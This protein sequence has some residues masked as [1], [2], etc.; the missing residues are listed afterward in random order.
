MKL[1]KLLGTLAALLALSASAST[2]TV[3]LTVTVTPTTVTVAVG[4]STTTIAVP[5]VVVTPPPVTTSTPTSVVYQNGVI[6]WPFNMSYGASVN[7]AD[8]AG[9][10]QSG[11][12]D[13]AITIT[14]SNGGGWQPGFSVACQNGGTGCF[15]TSA[16]KYF[17]FSFKPTKAGTSL[18][19]GWHMPG[20]VVDGNQG[21][22]IDQYCSNP[23]VGTWGTCKIPLSAFAF[24][25]SIVSK[26]G[27]QSNVPTVFYVNNVGFSAT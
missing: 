24:S 6:N 2:I 10:P 23:A 17:V 8:T 15:Q 20:D 9:A 22:I 26:F 4:G 21:V 14:P 19:M 27:I 13:A 7:Y 16:Y 25:N 12:Y 11:T 3:P 1:P 18:N 5:T